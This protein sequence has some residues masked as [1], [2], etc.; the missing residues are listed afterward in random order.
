[1]LKENGAPVSIPYVRLSTHDQKYAALCH[2]AWQAG[3][4]GTMARLN[5]IVIPAVQFDRLPFGKAVA[6]LR[7][8]AVLAAGDEAVPEVMVSKDGRLS[9]RPVSV[10]EAEWPLGEAL[11]TLCQRAEAVPLWH[12]KEVMVVDRHATVTR[13]YMVPPGFAPRARGRQTP[14]NRTLRTMFEH[15]GAEFPQGTGLRYDPA[16]G[17]MLVKNELPKLTKI[18][19]ILRE[20]L[21]DPLFAE[22]CIRLRIVAHRFDSQ[23]L[24]QV[25]DLLPELPEANADGSAYQRALLT[26]IEAQVAYGAVSRTPRTFELDQGCLSGH[27]VVERRRDGPAAVSFEATPEA[28]DDLSACRFELAFGAAMANVGTRCRG[29][30][31]LAPGEGVLLLS[32]AGPPGPRALFYAC[33]LL[34]AEIRTTPPERIPAAPPE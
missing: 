1:M 12:G 3:S 34:L 29:S 6:Q 18:E 23:V 14:Y 20:R 17:V 13:T 15:A 32:R 31:T 11:V 4:T 8:A 26:G 27:A 33:H 7:E 16:T 25:R 22:K 24:G 9:A 28:A 30:A 5:D 21:N 2:L 19:G 10:A